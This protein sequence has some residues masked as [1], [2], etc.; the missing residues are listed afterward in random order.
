VTVPAGSA[1]A[2]QLFK[3]DQS[4]VSNLLDRLRK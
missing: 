3:R 4:E 1:R 2:T